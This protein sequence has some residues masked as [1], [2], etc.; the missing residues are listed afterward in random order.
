MFAK[1]DRQTRHFVQSGRK[2]NLCYS[3]CVVFSYNIFL[4]RFFSSL[5][6]RHLAVQSSGFGAKF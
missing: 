3:L 5:I 6:P 2:R 4:H 1:N